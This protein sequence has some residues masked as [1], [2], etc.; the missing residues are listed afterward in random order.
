MN[1]TKSSAGDTAVEAF[2]SAGNYVI[3]NY[4]K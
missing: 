4:K 1:L 3:I 2:V